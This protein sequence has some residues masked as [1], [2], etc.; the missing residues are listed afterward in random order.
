MYGASNKQSLPV[1]VND[2]VK[3]FNKFRKSLPFVGIALA[4][5]TYYLLNF[6]SIGFL[7]SSRDVTSTVSTGNANIIN[8]YNSVINL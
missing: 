6:Y 1:D 7:L 5:Y 2:T 3:N 8:N 4:L